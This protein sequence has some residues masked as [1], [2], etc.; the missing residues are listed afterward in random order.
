MQRVTRQAQ[1]GGYFAPDDASNDASGAGRDFQNRR[2]QS[3]DGQS[4]DIQ[5]RDG[6]RTGLWKNGGKSIYLPG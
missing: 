3:R 1:K 5:S 2:G 4:R 6:S